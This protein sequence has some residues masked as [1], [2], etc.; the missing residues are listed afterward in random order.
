MQC[1]KSQQPTVLWEFIDTFSSLEAMKDIV[2][3]PLWLPE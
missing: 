2:L 1:H 3:I